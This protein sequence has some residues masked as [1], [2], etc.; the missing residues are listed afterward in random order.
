MSKESEQITNP[1]RSLAAAV[2]GIADY[3]QAKGGDQQQR[4]EAVEQLL[5]SVEDDDDGAVG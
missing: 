2:V 5:E 3:V 1:L 4:I